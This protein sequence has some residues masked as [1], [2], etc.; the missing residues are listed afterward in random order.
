[1]KPEDDHFKPGA[2]F[3][4]SVLNRYSSRYFAT[5]T[6]SVEAF[7]NSNK[8]A[9]STPAGSAPV[10]PKG[11][12]DSNSPVPHISLPP[13]GGPSAV[14]G[15]NWGSRSAFSHSL[16]YRRGIV[17]VMDPIIPSSSLSR[18]VD[19]VGYHA[20]KSALTGGYNAFL[21]MCDNF[22]RARPS[23]S[24]SASNEAAQGPECSS[25]VR[26]FFANTFTEFIDAAGVNSARGRL[27]QRSAHINP[28]SPVVTSSATTTA[29][30]TGESLFDP[31]ENQIS[32]VEV[33]D[34]H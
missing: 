27:A 8:N 14:L 11:Y 3:P 34:D 18:T 24:S 30:A 25:F 5:K 17:N 12:V 33:N 20:I 9:A 22:Q 29:T 2:L 6:A 13:S 7:E 19:G 26:Q 10:S 16:F 23:T 1:M 15:G 31:L 28:T 32:E 21:E 4:S